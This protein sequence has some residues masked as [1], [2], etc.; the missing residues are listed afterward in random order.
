MPSGGIRI[1]WNTSAVVC[2]DVNIFGENI[3]TM[4]KNT[5]ALLDASRKVGLEVRTEKTK[6]VVISSSTGEQR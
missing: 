2:A 6:C 4:K 5:K 3:L 1:E